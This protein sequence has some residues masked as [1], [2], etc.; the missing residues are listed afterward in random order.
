[1]LLALLIAGGMAGFAFS[2]KVDIYSPRPELDSEAGQAPDAL[3]A[4]V[5][6]SA[7][8]HGLRGGGAGGGGLTRVLTELEK[9]S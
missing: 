2:W 5:G 9:N 4:L 6:D 7:Q 3:A 8:V 1:M